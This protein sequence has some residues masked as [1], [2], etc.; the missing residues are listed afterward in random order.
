[1][2]AAWYERN[3]P[4]REVLVVGGVVY[5]VLMSF[6]VAAVCGYMAGLIGSSNSPLSGVGIP[7]IEVHLSNVHARE[8]FRH[9][10]YFSDKAIGTITGLGAQGYLLAFDYIIAALSDNL[11]PG[12][13]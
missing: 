8:E 2:R 10:S 4:A 9:Q 3:G 13:A 6:F 1:M 12:Q 11:D 5:V 7:F